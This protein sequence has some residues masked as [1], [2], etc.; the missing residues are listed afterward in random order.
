MNRGETAW[1]E[2][3]AAGITNSRSPY[4]CVPYVNTVTTA[5]RAFGNADAAILGGG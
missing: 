2:L 5:S 1:A 3:G 4:Q